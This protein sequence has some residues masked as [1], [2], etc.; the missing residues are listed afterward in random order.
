[1]SHGTTDWPKVIVFGIAALLVGGLVSHWL[2]PRHVT[3]EHTV[4]VSDASFQPEIG[5]IYSLDSFRVVEAYE[6]VYLDA[7]QEAIRVTLTI[8]Q[9]DQ[10]DL[11]FYPV[12]TFNNNAVIWVDQTVLPNNSAVWLRTNNG[13]VVLQINA[14]HRRPLD[15]PPDRT[16]AQFCTFASN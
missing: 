5:R 4:Y 8:P 16:L 7:K 13:Q 10:Q 11:V 12:V 6:S 3:Q 14:K 2:L 15:G 9:P 1:M